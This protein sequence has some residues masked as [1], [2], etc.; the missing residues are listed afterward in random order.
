MRVLYGKLAA[1]TLALMMVV[2]GMESVKAEGAAGDTAVAGTPITFEEAV[3]IALRKNITLAQAQNA[4]AS[5]AAT[6]RGAKLSF[7]PNL[8]LNTSGA[9]TYGRNFSETTGDV[10]N[11]NTQSLNAGISSSITLFNGMQNVATLHE[12]EKNQN[13]STLDLTRA[14]QTTVFTVASNYL[15]IITAQEQLKVQQQNLAS[16]QAQE[17]QIKKMVDA[18]ARAISDL[19]S[20]QASTAAARLGVV[21]AKH[22]LE[23]GK[24]DLVQTLNLDPRVTYDFIAPAVNESATSKYDL[25]SLTTRAYA[26]RADLAAENA[27]VDASA[28]GVKAAN[29][30]WWP[31]VSMTAGYNSAYSTAT[32]LPF[33]NQL[34]Q[35]RGGSI[36]IG[37]SVPIFDR[38]QTSVAAQ[39][40]RVQEDNAKLALDAQKQQVA[41][42]VK[43]AYLD[44]QSAGEQLAAAQAQLTAS[45]RA[46]TTSQQRYQAGAGTL[47]ELTQA[48]AA[49]VQAASAVVNARYGLVFQQALMSYYTGEL[50]PAHVVLNG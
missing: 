9:Q 42:E 45:D 29:A 21:T 48:R 27:R 30:G 33:F 41:V 47:V 16:L 40:A 35:A 2:G 34:D 11:R 24:V 32:G 25:D 12:A 46:V 19:Y 44:F 13:A 3:Q 37:V 49:Q 38:G 6:V 23:I 4:V 15:S 7:L 8:Q 43:R 14:K 50:D 22:D 28:Q 5:D 20:Q 17:D 36:S 31:T 18:G 10:L 26:Q 1:L 39:K